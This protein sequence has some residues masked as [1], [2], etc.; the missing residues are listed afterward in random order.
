MLGKVRERKSADE[1]GTVCVCV[2][3]RLRVMGVYAKVCVTHAL[4][5]MCMCVGVSGWLVEVEVSG[6]QLK[7]EREKRHVS[8]NCHSYYHY[9]YLLLLLL[10]EHCEWDDRQLMW[11]GIREDNVPRSWLRLVYTSAPRKSA[12]FWN[13]NFADCPPAKIRNG[14]VFLHASSCESDC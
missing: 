6:C 14:N 1:F 7:G 3:M 2:W 13:L 8:C 11:G 9:Y 10:H 12:C 4:V 5:C